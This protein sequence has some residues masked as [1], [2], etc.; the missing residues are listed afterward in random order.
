M[1]LSPDIIWNSLE[2]DMGYLLPLGESHHETI[3]LQ[4]ADKVYLFF[5]MLVAVF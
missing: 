5:I 1:A 2:E 3:V 4:P